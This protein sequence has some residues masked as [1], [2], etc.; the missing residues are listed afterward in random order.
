MGSAQK[1]VIVRYNP[2]SFRVGLAT[3]AV[4]KKDRLAKLVATVRD[5]PEPSS[6]LT[7]LFL[8]YD[9]DSEDAA[10]PTIAHQWDVAARVVS[11][12]A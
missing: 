4:S 10:M 7:R 1:L 9:R 6:L 3:R 2:N 12:N 8:F 11:R 5:M